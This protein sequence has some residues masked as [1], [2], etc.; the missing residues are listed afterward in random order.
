MAEKK[1]LC[2]QIPTA[3]HEQVCEAREAAGLTTAQYITNLLTEYYEMKKNGGNEIMANTNTRT[4]A[5][6]VGEDLFQR[7]KAHLE[8]ETIRT[9]KKL[10]QREFVLGLIMDALETAEQQAGTDSPEP[11]EQAAEELGVSR[12]PIRDAIRKLEQDG[13]VRMIHRKGAQVANITEKDLT[14]VLEVRIGLERMA[15]DKACQMIGREQLDLLEQAAKGF[16]EAIQGG[17]LTE[18]AEADKNFHEII[19]SVSGNKCLI[20]MQ[21]NLR[22]QVY[23]YRMEYL[24][25][26]NVRKILVEEHGQI[27]DAIRERDAEKAKNIIYR[28][29]ENQRVGIIRSIRVG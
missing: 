19:Y 24:K 15:I 9:G 29:I 14:D 3:L 20:E 2:A 18:M 11:E 5:F 8:R 6:Q 21:A 25:E 27:V 13:L 17:D 1:N 4:M 28:H 16:E 26:E 10:T 7:I 12:T 23:R 22:E